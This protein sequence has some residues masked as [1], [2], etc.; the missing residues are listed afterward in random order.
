MAAGA[1]KHPATNGTHAK[2]TPI[3]LAIALPHNPGTRIHLHLTILAT[4]IVLFI[5]SANIDAGQ[6]GAALGSFVYAMPDVRLLT[7]KALTRIENPS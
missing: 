7:V 6:A 1:S 3:E 2:D 4:S 5:A